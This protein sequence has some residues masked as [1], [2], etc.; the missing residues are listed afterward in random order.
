[1]RTEGKH[2]HGPGNDLSALREPIK[3]GTG[4][5]PVRAWTDSE[6]RIVPGAEITHGDTEVHLECLFRLSPE[7]R[8]RFA[9]KALPASN[10]EI[11]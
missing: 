3:E 11:R 4:R 1:V 6:G 9:L 2:D 5:S 7:E 10:D 8:H